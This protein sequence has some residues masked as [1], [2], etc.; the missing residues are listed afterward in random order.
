M[1]AWF[2]APALRR[3]VSSDGQFYVRRP[4]SKDEYRLESG[5]VVGLLRRA[6]SRKG[7]HHWL[8]LQNVVRH[9]DYER[10][11]CRDCGHESDVVWFCWTERRCPECW[12]VSVD[13]LDVRTMPPRPRVFRNIG[14]PPT[15]MYSVAHTFDDHIWGRAI[16]DDIRMLRNLSWS[17][18]WES[19]GYRDL[20]VL[21]LL[22]RSLAG[23][24]RDDPDYFSLLLNVGNVSQRYFRA[25]G[26]SQAAKATLDAFNAAIAAADDPDATLLGLHSFAMAVIYVLDTYDERHAQLITGQPNLRHVAIDGLREAIRLNDA[27]ADEDPEMTAVQHFRMQYA[28]ADLLRRGWATDAELD[29]AMSMFETLD[30]SLADKQGLGLFVRAARL[31]TRLSP[32]PSEPVSDAE[33]ESLASAMHEL[34]ELIY[35]SKEGKFDHRWHWALSIGQCLARLGVPDQARLWLESAITFILEDTTF[36]TDPVAVAGDAERYHQAFNTLATIYVLSGRAFEGLALLETYRGRALDLAALDDE[37]RANRAGELDHAARHK[38]YFIPWLPRDTVTQKLAAEEVEMGAGRLGPFREDYELPGLLA[39]VDSL[40][41]QLDDVPTALVSLS[42]DENITTSGGLISAVVLR[43]PG[44]PDP[45]CRFR[46]WHLDAEHLTGLRSELYRRPGSFRERRL[47]AL[48]ELIHE[49]L[50]APIADHLCDMGCERVLCIT[51]SWISNLPIEAHVAAGAANDLPRHVA[52]LP[53]LMFG[54]DARPSRRQQQNKEEEEKKDKTEEQRRKKKK[55]KKKHPESAQ[56]AAR[57]PTARRQARCLGHERLLI[58]GYQGA[59]L[60]HAADEVAALE[61]LFAERASYLP[62]EKCTKRRV[63]EQLNGDYEYIHLICHGTFDANHPPES[64]LIFRDRPDADAYRLRAHEIESMVRFP[65][66]PIVT[67][68]ACSTALTADSRSNT[69]TGLPGALMRVGARCIVGTRW[70]VRDAAAA[71]MM[72]YFYRTLINTDDEPITCFFA[73]QDAQRPSGRLE[74]WACFGYLGLP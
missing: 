72:R 39:Q 14:K 17:Y 55:K 4:G 23:I 70:P 45:R 59:D 44:T 21:S 48:G 10:W 58:V 63:V 9:L 50:L 26:A 68:S 35:G 5:D 12:S 49:H 19:S 71:Q 13:V 34:G 53:A 24:Y 60:C 16:D 6:A 15:S 22:A 66:R 43:P 61:T 20:Y 30:V 27:R 31:E 56:Q 38:K 57:A 33:L 54:A 2:D 28:L 3:A 8:S 36:R 37:G 7:G 42:L 25:T 47:A 67:L 40:H 51:P 65:R 74:D 62:G 32:R 52:F 41:A 73:M 29:E 11:R 69:W 18:R 46:T 64:A 1:P